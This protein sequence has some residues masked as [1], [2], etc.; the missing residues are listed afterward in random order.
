MLE[1]CPKCDGML[2]VGNNFITV[3]G[4]HSPDT[5]TEVFMNLPRICINPA[6]D[7]CNPDLNNLSIIIETQ[8]HKIY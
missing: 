7:N 4:D 5:V 6:C 1:N 8:V 3:T 2:Y